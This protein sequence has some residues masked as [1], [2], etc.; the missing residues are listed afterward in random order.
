[1]CKLQMPCEWRSR[2]D[3]GERKFVSDGSSE[4][5]ND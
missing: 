4:F 3:K 1:L 2:E 5:R